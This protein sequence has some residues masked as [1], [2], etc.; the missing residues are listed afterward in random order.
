M[1]FT[2]QDCRE[3]LLCLFSRQWGQHTAKQDTDTQPSSCFSLTVTIWKPRGLPHLQHTR[4]GAWQKQKARQNAQVKKLFSEDS[5]YYQRV[6]PKGRA[7]PLSPDT[8][9]PNTHCASQKIN[10]PPSFMPVQFQSC[11]WIYFSM[12]PYTCW[13]WHKAEWGAEEQEGRIVFSR[14]IFWTSK[15]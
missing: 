13:C 12:R 10:K 11:P 15:F 1:I 4:T 9:Q 5:L 3:V 7:L 2:L 6:G 14:G 8:S